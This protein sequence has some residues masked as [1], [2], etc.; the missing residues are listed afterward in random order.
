MRKFPRE[1]RFELA[2]QMRRSAR[3]QCANFAEG[4]G[5]HSDWDFAQ[6]V[7]IAYGSL[8]EVASDAYLAMDSGYLT[9][10]EVNGILDDAEAIA[11]KA[12]GLYRRLTGAP[13]SGAQRSALRSPR[14]GHA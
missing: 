8:M 4:A 1:E 10:T 11:S 13:L 3:S 2:S 7:E 6:F 14:Q 9:E 12:S 5:R